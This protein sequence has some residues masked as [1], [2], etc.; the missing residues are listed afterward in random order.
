MTSRIVED[1]HPEIKSFPWTSVSFSL[2]DPPAATPVETHVEDV[3]PL[4]GPFPDEEEIRRQVEQSFQ[5]GYRKGFSEGEKQGAARVQPAI[6]R[7]AQSIESLAAYKPAFRRE[8]QEDVVRLAVEIARRILNREMTI[9]AEALVGLVNVAFSRLDARE[10]HHVSVHPKD[11]P[12]IQ[13]LL[14]HMP[15]CGQ[16][17]V[18]ADPRLEPGSVLFETSRGTL[19]ASV[20]TQ[21]HEIE[22]GLLDRTA[23]LT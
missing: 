11:L 8:V 22:R 4:P 10:I 18:I 21:L 19:D 14:S 6:E 15:G 9:D 16:L 7:L 1:N 20:T 3:E 5:D 17:E 2:E 12:F 23:R 13:S